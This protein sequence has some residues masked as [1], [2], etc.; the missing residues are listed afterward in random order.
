MA[1]K[2]NKN[3][4]KDDKT[5]DVLREKVSHNN[6]DKR[7]RRGSSIGQVSQQRNDSNNNSIIHVEPDNPIIHVEPDNPWPRK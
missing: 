1:K 6:P 4:V 2:P 5:D 3:I 7:H